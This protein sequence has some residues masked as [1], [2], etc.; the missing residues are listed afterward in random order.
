MAEEA[1]SVEWNKAQSSGLRA[2]NNNKMPTIEISK[3]DLEE[4]CGKKFSEQELS[5]LLECVKGEVESVEGDVVKIDM[6]DVNRPDLWSTSGIA[7][8]LKGELGKETGLPKISAENSNYEVKVDPAL[9]GI[10]PLTV[11][12]VVRG[13]KLTKEGI[14]QIIALQEKLSENY[15]R[16]RREAAIGVYDADMIKW[17]LNY[18]AADPDKT[19][20]TP[21]EG[22]KPLTLR[23]ILQQHEKGKKYGKLLE[24]QKQYPIFIDYAGEILSMPPIINSDASGKV[25]ERTR[26]VFIE[27]SGNSFRFITPC[28]L[29]I[30]AELADRGGQIEAVQ[31]Q[32]K[33]KKMTTPD[34]KPGK[35]ELE[36]EECN[37]LLGLALNAQELKAMLEKRRHSV[38]IKYSKL[39]VEFPAYRQ[40]IM[41]ARDIIEDVAISYGYNKFK[42]QEPRIA[43]TGARNPHAEKEEKIANL[44]VGLGMQEIATLTLTSKEE[45][46]RKMMLKEQPVA[47]LENPV[48]LTHSILRRS[49]IPELLSFLEKNKKARYAQKV[50]ELGTCIEVRGKKASDERKLAVTISHPTASYTEAR[51]VLDYLLKSFGVKYEIKEKESPS[52][53][54]GRGASILIGGSGLGARST[55]LRALSAG[56]GAG[57]EVAIIGEVHPQILQNFGIEMPTSVFELNLNDLF[58]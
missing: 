57:K 48:S 10:R 12:A 3:R 49:I 26:N 56:L 51:Q 41:H 55:E 44:L 39:L 42:P 18:R 25:T 13:L 47:E 54:E 27:V 24:E 53:I 30:V 22:S 34:F 11:C 46:F 14:E 35:I 29:V 6:K 45:Q 38:E 37:K 36:V 2:G 23:Q 7:R 32:Y 19:K 52:F 1:G 28:L 50:F 16:G 4:M 5:L 31:V 15:G 9:E 58:L 21:L 43:T 40:D 20:F 8:E 33:N 17:P